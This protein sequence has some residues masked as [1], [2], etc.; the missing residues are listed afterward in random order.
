MQLMKKDWKLEERD[1]K[2]V[3]SKTV[4]RI[5]RLQWTIASSSYNRSQN[6]KMHVQSYIWDQGWIKEEDVLCIFHLQFLQKL[7][8]SEI[9]LLLCIQQD[10]NLS[11]YLTLWIMQV[12]RSRSGS[13]STASPRTLSC[14]SQ[15]PSA[16]PRPLPPPPWTR[17]QVPPLC[18]RSSVH[19]LLIRAS[20]ATAPSSSPPSSM[21][22]CVFAST[23]FHFSGLAFAVTIFFICSRLHE[24]SFSMRLRHRCC[25]FKYFR[26]V[27]EL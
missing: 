4:S 26:L 18:S 25:W 5:F 11:W 10:S 14:T 9:L 20:G 7:E 22:W 27:L 21:C 19:F 1:N 17:G 23:L 2:G 13:R 24:A 16:S 12:W 8:I 15:G 6:S 3:S